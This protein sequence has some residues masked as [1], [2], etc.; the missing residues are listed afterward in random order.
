MW[1]AKGKGQNPLSSRDGPVRRTVCFLCSALRGQFAE[2]LIRLLVSSLPI[3][4]IL[5]MRDDFYSRVSEEV[6]DLLSWI[7]A[8]ISNIRTVLEKDDLTA[9]IQGP[10]KTV[11][12]DVEPLLIKLI[13]EHI[14]AMDSGA[15]IAGKAGRSS[16]LPLLEFALTLVWTQRRD[17]V[18]TASSYESVGGLA[19]ALTQWADDAYRRFDKESQTLVERVF[20]NL[21]HV[22]NETENT[23]DTR[24]CDVRYSRYVQKVTQRRRFAVSFGGLADSRLLVTYRDDQT[25]QESVEIIHDALI[26]EW[27]RL[28]QWVAD[29]K[30]FLLWRQFIED[31]AQACR[32]T[33]AT[34]EAGWDVGRLLRGRDLDEA[35]AQ[36]TRRQLES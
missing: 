20:K 17:G 29:D 25:K 36:L 13:E 5:V 34:G 2:E 22:G 27:G 15:S 18:L 19:G 28:R 26:R 24:H 12:L 21:I 3:T 9:M 16:V 11:G 30:R 10:A 6:P 8:G 31:R 35:E 1:L 23:P 7:E 33:K 4:V 14:L 32:E